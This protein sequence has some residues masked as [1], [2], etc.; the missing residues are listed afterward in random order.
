MFVSELRLSG[1]RNIETETVHFAPGINILYGDNAQGKTNIL[2]SVY[3][4]TTG[5]SHRTKIDSQLISFSHK[6]AHVKAF[7]NKN[8]T[9]NNTKNNINKRNPRIDR[10]DVHIKKDDKKGIAVNGIPVRKS[11]DLFGTLYCV[12]FSPEDLQL[13]KNSPAERRRYIDIELCQLSKI[14]YHDLQQYYKVLKQRNNL[15]KGIVKDI[16]LKETIFVWDNQL[17]EYGKKVIE[18]RE[19]FVSMLSGISSGIHSAVTDGTESLEILYKPNCQKDELAKKIKSSLDKDLFYGSTSSGPHKDDIAFY[20]NGNDVKIFGSQGQQR[21]AALSAKLAE[22]DIIK[23]ETGHAPVL[24]LDDVLSELDEKRQTYL[25]ENLGDIQ[26][27]LTCTGIEDSIKKYE[28]LASVFKV[29]KGKIYNE[30]RPDG[31]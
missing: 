27:I 8:N 12:M 29:E 31:E 5:R 10:I 20:V 7:V 24:L 25:L 23:R 30:K 19:S 22:I 26:T 18:S 3:L 28:S 13:I 1:F 16:G 21:T 2:E 4:C 11:V 15:L 14:Y 9:V 6:E 17:V